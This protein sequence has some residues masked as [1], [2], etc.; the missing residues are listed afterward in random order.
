MCGIAGILSPRGPFEAGDLNAMTGS[1]R[2]RGPDDS[3]VWIHREH[4]VG[5]GHRRLS[6]LD[7]SPLGRQP[8]RSRC[9]RYTLAYNGE[10]Y[11]FRELRAE[12]EALGHAFRGGSDTEV[13][14]A[15][16]AQWGVRR[17][18][19]RFNGM[20]AFALWD[21]RERTLSLVRDRVGVK[22]LY[23][24]WAGTQFLFGSELKALRAHSGFAG[25]LDRN[26]LALYFR[27]GYIPAPHTIYADA[28][29][30]EPGRIL[31]VGPDGAT[32][33]ERFWSAL[34]VWNQGAR[35]PFAG[36]LREAVDELERLLD[37]AV[38]R[39]MVADVPLGA[40]LS[41]GIDSSTV[42]A[43]MQKNSARPVRTFSIGFREKAYNEA[44]HA[45][46]VAGHLGTD[47]T[48][49]FVT[50]EDMLAAAAHI[51]RHWDEPF[52][53]SS[54][55]PTLL[56]SSLTRAS[57]TV[58]L[59]GDGGD[60]LFAGYPRYFATGYYDR[61]SRLPAGLR[62]MLAPLAALVPAR[63]LEALGTPGHKLRWRLDML[64][65]RGFDDFYKYFL[66]HDQRP[67]ELVP[68]AHEPPCAMTAALD[69]RFED[70]IRRMTLLDMLAYLP[71]DI[72]TKTDR[73]SMAHGL[74]LRVPLLDHRVVEWAAALPTH[75]KVAGGQGKRVLRSL[76]Y[77]YVPR[78]LVDRPKMGFGVPVGEWL[79][80]PLR[81]W[82]RDMLDTERIR[83]QG[84]L[85]AGAV[86]AR[87]ERFM[88]GEAA[89]T[90]RIWDLLMLQAWV[91]EW[92]R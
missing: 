31:T 20:F 50:P 69:M 65:V 56:V 18:C 57:V 75:L 89:L 80:G 52:A 46:A 92:K 54:Q 59:S 12:L 8:M 2:H 3:L 30:L 23:Y 34:D 13:V 58:A 26:A 68:G 38:A 55:L 4:G 33:A 53:D 17:A 27:Y 10:V 62:R 83:R 66:C 11:N 76:L 74:E 6:I 28:R 24:G 71:D 49:L 36:D 21:G 37:D 22:P 78:D 32:S 42:A 25:S 70:R 90:Q 87:L 47:H 43:L 86:A 35:R 84:L 79:R 63:L 40:L 81:Q 73:A 44:R 7:P 48:E 29:K 60:E 61:L 41:G 77:R 16:L 45:K 72:L 15:A 1:L 91:E 51:P 39:C 67:A 85:D 82:C 19:A 88:R 64:S 14:L 9:G 5:L